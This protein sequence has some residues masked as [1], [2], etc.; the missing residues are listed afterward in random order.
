MSIPNTLTILI[1]TNIRGSTKLVYKPFMTIPLKDDEK[2]KMNNVCFDPIIKMSSRVIYDIPQYANKNELYT[3]FFNRNEF[4]SLVA[5]TIART[6]QKKGVTLYSATKMGYVD[7]NIRATLNALFR[8]NGPFYIKGKEYIINNYKWSQ[9]DWRIDTKK[10]ESNFVGSPYLSTIMAITGVSSQIAMANQK[11]AEDEL[12]QIPP[13]IRA[14]K[15]T[16]GQI[17]RFEQEQMTQIVPEEKQQPPSS[18]EYSKIQDP[19]ITKN[20]SPDTQ[21]LVKNLIYNPLFVKGEF[22]KEDY[23][24]LPLSFVTLFYDDLKFNQLREKYPDIEKAFESLT[25][26]KTDLDQYQELFEEQQ[27][28]FETNMGRYQ[29][30]TEAFFNYVTTNKSNNKNINDI[31]YD[32]VDKKYTEN[33]DKL[34]KII[35]QINYFKDFLLGEIYTVSNSFYTFISKYILYVKQNVNFLSV[36][37]KTYIKEKQNDIKQYKIQLRDLLISQD[38]QMYEGLLNNQLLSKNIENT[39]DILTIFYAYIKE[40]PFGFST[41]NKN[42]NLEEIYKYYKNPELIILEYEVVNLLSKQIFINESTT[43]LYIE[44]Y[45]NNSVKNTKTF[46]LQETIK[47]IETTKKTYYDFK[48]KYTEAQIN[49]LRSAIDLKKKTGSMIP[50]V[51]YIGKFKKEYK[52]L[53][54]NVRELIDL[55]RNIVLCYDMIYLSIDIDLYMFSRNIT[56]LTEKRNYGVVLLS[57]LQVENK[58]YNIL[59]DF[60]INKKLDFKKDLNLIR[61]F[62]LLEINS[63]EIKLEEFNENNLDFKINDNEKTINKYSTESKL[64]F[65][66]IN[67]YD[68][69]FDT[70]VDQ[71]IKQFDNLIIEK[72]CYDIMNVNIDE[73]YK[74][75]VTASNVIAQDIEL[76]SGETIKNPLNSTHS[77]QQKKTAT[78]PANIPPQQ[79]VSTTKQTDSN[80]G[81]VNPLHSTHAHQQQSQTQTPIQSQ[82][83]SQKQQLVQ[84]QKNSQKIANVINMLE[85]KR[86]I[87]DLLSKTIQNMFSNLKIT[88]ESLNLIDDNRTF[89][90][91]STWKVIENEGGGDCFFSSISQALNFQLLTNQSLLNEK[92]INSKYRNSNGLFSVSTLRNAVADGFTTEIYERY[93]YQAEVYKNDDYDN[94]E[95]R[96]FRFMFNEDNTIKTI[97]EVKQEIKKSCVASNNPSGSDVLGNGSYWG[98]EFSVSIIEEIFG[99]KLVILDTTNTNKFQDNYFVKFKIRGENKIGLIDKVTNK[100]YDQNTKFPS[101]IEELDTIQEIEITPEMM[102]GNRMGIQISRNYFPVLSFSNEELNNVKNFIF[103]VLSEVNNVQHYTLLCNFEIKNNNFVNNPLFVFNYELIPN[104]VKYLIFLTGYKNF[105]NRFETSYAKV[106][107]LGKYLATLYKKYTELKMSRLEDIYKGGADEQVSDGSN[108]GQTQVP[109][110]RQI[111]NNTSTPTSTSTKENPVKSVLNKYSQGTVDA[112]DLSKLSYYVIID[113][114]IIEKGPWDKIPLSIK[115]KMKCAESKE[116]IRR[117]YSELFNLKYEP[118]ELNI[119]TNYPQQNTYIPKPNVSTSITEKKGGSFSFNKTRKIN[120]YKS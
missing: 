85:N 46:F 119:Q 15:L 111:V 42:R 115:L 26:S 75:Y 116:K 8:A 98:D 10:I 84:I 34:V 1:N 63:K 36:L 101:V 25:A 92:I 113:L 64:L 44:T 77:V 93:Y 80:S 88:G 21:K 57:F 3:Q 104:Y 11:I 71:K 106:P 73:L 82:I 72:K 49:M 45:Y 79:P 50:N 30:L 23:T 112:K 97:D 65:A 110:D 27:K 90:E 100:P 14:G 89:A 103:I 31:I 91:P 78:P 76:T 60:M 48:N 5:R 53:E 9:G 29:S 7:N 59:F 107:L 17:S 55:E 47:Q 2:K 24:G 35:S 118:E 120:R 22:K 67:S 114:S 66:E 13:E 74:N 87:N 109:I 58:I 37:E 61:L 38:I 70:Y 54:T 69:L 96:K 99:T 33:Y 86:I 56:L 20:F 68:T 94:P 51:G 95:K 4:D 12:N 105:K 41:E 6:S 32:R 62:K 40:N 19:N 18:S 16:P 108:A 117:A 81:V 43:T 83:K 28:N 52:D 102:A 39:R